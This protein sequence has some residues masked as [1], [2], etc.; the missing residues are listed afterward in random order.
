[1][2]GV[3]ESLVRVLLVSLESVSAALAHGHSWL[4]QVALDEALET[5]LHQRA[6]GLE[7]SQRLGQLVL[8]L[9]VYPLLG[10]AMRRIKY[11]K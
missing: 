4:D 3:V 10:N 11:I 8:E 5:I 1:M 7:L 6:L 9:N 2:V